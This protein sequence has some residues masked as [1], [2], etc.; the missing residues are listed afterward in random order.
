MPSIVY[1][2][3]DGRSFEVDAPVGTSVMDAA[4]QNNIPGIDGDCGGQ[5]ACGTCHVIVSAEDAARLTAPSDRELEMLSMVDLAE[6]NSR[7]SCQIKV[8]ASP[9]RLIVRLPA[10]QH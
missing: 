4:V 6:P 7:L 10:G 5:A 3:H 8:C 2:T 9:A 1:C